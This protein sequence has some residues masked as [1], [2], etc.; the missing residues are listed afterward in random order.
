MIKRIER[1]ADIITGKKDLE[2]LYSFPAFP[3]FMGCTT[4]PKADDIVSDMSFW[5]SRSSGMI[6]LNPLLPLDVLYPEAHG[7]GCVG[8]SWAKH[9]KALADF[10]GNLNPISVLEIGGAH[11]IL[12][13][14]YQLIKKIPWTILEPN[15]TPIH[16]CEAL[17]IKG[18]FDENFKCTDEVDTV[19]HSHVFEHIY[20]P[21]LFVKHLSDFLTTGKKLIFSVPNMRVMLERKYTNCLNFEHTIYL[22]EEYIDYLLVK[23]GFVICD[24]KYFLDDHSIFYSAI[25]THKIIPAQLSVNL[26][27][28]NKKKYL[29]YVEYHVKLVKNINQQLNTETKSRVFLF[30]AHVQAQYLIGFGLDLSK[31]DAILDNDVQK[32]GKRLYGTDKKVASPSILHGLEA[33]V[34]IIRAGT[35]TDEIVAQIKIINSTTQFIV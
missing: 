10:L 12:A 4:A 1:N 18:F 34:V 15:P 23:H 19:V 32:S 6:Q 20:N 35:F 9:H 31:V 33:P 14:N 25:R 5:I 16:E 11:G 3:V 27:D 26:Y 21:D 29:D 24:K 30:G 2:H 7:A 13:T 17:I 22:S 8:T 28:I